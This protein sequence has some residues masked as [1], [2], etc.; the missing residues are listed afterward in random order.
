MG[1]LFSN[2]LAMSVAGSVVVGLMLLFQPVTKK[3]FPAKWQY[4]MGKMAITFFLV[5]VSL[6]VG[7]LFLLLSAIKNY[8]SGLPTIQEALRSNSFM[9]TMYEKHLSPEV[10]EAILL[11]WFVGAIVFTAWHFYCYRR[12]TKELWAD[13]IPVPKDAEAAVFLSSCKT[14]LGIHRE[15]KLMQNCKI[16]C[17]MIVGLFRPMILLPTL[18][19]QEIDFKLVLT[20]E[21]T[22]LKRK[23]LWVKMLALAV[24]TLHWFNPL[25][26]FLRKDV[27][28]W[29]EL[30]C[31]EVLASEM[32]HGERKRY[33]EAILNTLD[34][35][36]SIKRTSV[37]HYARAGST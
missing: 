30:S 24:G 14:V 12:F 26:H 19:M 34:I 17:P 25:A 32:S 13:S 9:D 33:G 8:H 10:L 31:D 20:H 15:V 4:S 5:P 6:F 3:I 23:D 21:L 1:S 18:K 36:A 7:K 28:T 16:A 37:L 11:I 29:C 35:H 22:H 27:N 2:L